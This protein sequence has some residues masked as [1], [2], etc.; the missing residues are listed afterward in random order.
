MNILDENILTDQRQLL[1]K[2]SISFRQ[3]GYE[4]GWKGM[5]DDRIIPFLLTFPKPT[6][7]TSDADFYKRG[8]CHSRYGIVHLD[9]DEAETADFIRRVLRDRRFDTHAKRMG[10]VI[11]AS[12]SGTTVWSRH[13]EREAHYKWKD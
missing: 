5:K 6:L 3:I 11:R 7:F 4:V 13:A 8:L 10:V 1:I 2:W 12:H 9:V